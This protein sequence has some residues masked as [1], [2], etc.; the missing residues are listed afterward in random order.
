MVYKVEIHETQ[1]VECL[2]DDVHIMLDNLKFSKSAERKRTVGL[3]FNSED[4]RRFQSC[5]RI[6]WRRSD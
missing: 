3:H 5:H 1:V 4:T 2:K 6:L